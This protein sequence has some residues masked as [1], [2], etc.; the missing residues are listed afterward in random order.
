[1]ETS[2]CQAFLLFIFLGFD[3]KQILLKTEKEDS[4]QL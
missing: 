4:T 1:M 3:F 2:L